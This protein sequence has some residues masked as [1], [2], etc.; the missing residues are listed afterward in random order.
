MTGIVFGSLA[1]DQIPD[2]GSKAELLGLVSTP[3]KSVG[4]LSTGYQDVAH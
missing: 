2:E 3:F 1:S 4:K